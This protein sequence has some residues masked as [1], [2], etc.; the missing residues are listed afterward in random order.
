M[1]GRGPKPVFNFFRV[2]NGKLYLNYIVCTCIFNCQNFNLQVLKNL[3]PIE[4]KVK[5]F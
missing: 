1:P 4:T 3:Q 5:S 2:A